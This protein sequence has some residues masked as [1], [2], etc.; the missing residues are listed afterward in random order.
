[1]KADLCGKTRL[2]KAF[3]NKG[4][5]AYTVAGDPSVKESVI[6]AKA[7]VRGGCDVLELGVPFS[8]PVADGPVIQKADKRALDAGITVDGVFE[9]VRE[10]RKFSDVPLVFLVYCNIVF[11]RGVDR[12]YDE[13][14]EA[15]VDGILIVDMPPEESGPALKASKRTGIAQIFLVTQ[16]TSDERLDKIVEMASGFVY[17]VSTLGV[18]GQRAEVSEKAFPLLE[19][20]EAKTS[21]PVA[22]G[23]GISKPEHAEEI[24]GHGADGVIVGSAI[25]SII[26]KF[27]GKCNGESKDGANGNEMTVTDGKEKDKETEEMCNE[28]SE[29][30]KSMKDAMKNVMR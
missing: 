21:V 9:V 6:A 22:V 3:E 1:M 16:T 4:F 10:I 20:V 28:L 19:K 14:K 13:A 24:V 7:L 8:D 18:T 30:V 26:E 2:A 11:R 29:Y 27:S 5:V 17:L 25:V 23:F 12:F 15:G